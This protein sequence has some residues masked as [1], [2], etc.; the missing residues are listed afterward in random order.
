MKN[1]KRV[2][3]LGTILCTL[4]ALTGCI[5]SIYKK[6]VEYSDFPDK[7]IPIYDDAVVFSFERDGEKSEIEYGSEDTVEDIMEFY[8]DEFD[9]DEYTVLKEN[10]KY[11]DEYYVEGY[12]DDLYFEIDI[13][14]ASKSLEKYFATTVKMSVE[15]YVKK[16]E[17]STADKK[18]EMLE[19]EPIQ[20][21]E[22]QPET[23]DGYDIREMDQKKIIHFD[24]DTISDDIKTLFDE[25]M[26]YYEDGKY[27]D[28]AEN[29]L[30]CAKA[31]H[32]TAQ[33]MTGDCYYFGEGV[34]ANIDES[35]SW[36]MKG[37]WQ[38]D[39]HSQY[40]L[41]YMY[42]YGEGVEADEDIGIFL[43]KC[44]AE[45]GYLYAQEYLGWCYESG[46]FVK[47]DIKEAVFWY[48]MAAEQDDINVILWLAEYYLYGTKETDADYE[49]AVEYYEKAANLGSTDAAYS[50][51][52]IYYLGIHFDVDYEKAI[53]YLQMGLE[54]GDSRCQYLMGESYYFGNGVEQDYE[55]CAEYYKMAAEQGLPIAMNNYGDL[56]ETGMGVELDYDQ[57]FYWY[58]KAVAFGDGVAQYNVGHFYYEGWSVERNYNMAVYYY[59]LSANQGTDCGQ[60]GLAMCYEN[61]NGVE[62]DLPLAKYYYQLAADQGYED[63]VEALKRF[64]DIEAADEPEQ[65]EPEDGMHGL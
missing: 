56:F 60:Y 8:K 6:G 65:E 29:F 13:E 57:A 7:D 53:E 17:E 3:L 37:A 23:A 47:R 42:L 18:G 11:D 55:K 61:G 43:L 44:S 40:S 25:G 2:I 32:P 48:S 14:E 19:D 5:P 63:A 59:E 33:G 15:P 27:R 50:L 21:D 52:I 9:S 54:Q 34:E 39:E 62:Q 30:E 12:T 36:Y 4:I 49:K 28:A 58:T 1:I 45:Q 35:I 22:V 10:D 16:E 26:A 31:G 41:G 24:W 46:Q 51:A 20:E 38:G 64:D